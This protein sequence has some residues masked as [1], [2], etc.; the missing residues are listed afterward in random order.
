M[1]VDACLDKHIDSTISDFA[2]LNSGGA[3]AS[4]GALFIKKFIKPG[5][6][7][8]HLDIAAMAWSK[9]G[10]AISPAG[11][12]G[13]GVRLFDRYIRDHVEGKQKA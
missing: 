12:T 6:A 13:F 4:A 10:S 7:W 9:G 2:N 11:A 3:G 8:A 1:P 5:V